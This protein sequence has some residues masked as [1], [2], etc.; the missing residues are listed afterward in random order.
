MHVLISHGC[1]N[2]IHACRSA[3][4]VNNNEYCLCFQRRNSFLYRSYVSP[5]ATIDSST[6]LMLTRRYYAYHL[7]RVSFIQRIN[8]LNF[9]EEVANY[10]KITFHLFQYICLI[11]FIRLN[12]CIF[13]IQS[14]IEF[15]LLWFI[16]IS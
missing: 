13:Y 9:R 16:C 4:I 3:Y 11:Y 5:S 15:F 7:I 12:N 14:D 10:L 1:I 2:Q 6:S 8:E